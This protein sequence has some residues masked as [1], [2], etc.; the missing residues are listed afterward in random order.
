MLDGDD[1]KRNVEQRQRDVFSMFVGAGPAKRMT[2]GAL[3]AATGI[4]KSSLADYA[5]GVAMPLHNLLRLV[6]ALPKEAADMLIAPSG[7]RFADIETADANWDKIAAEAA[8]LVSEVC[9]ARSDGVIDHQEEARLKKMTRKLIAD[10]L[11][12][13]GE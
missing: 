6:P 10:A 4:S 12:A 8:G 7:K 3:A 1:F 11:G 5:N 2:F 13:V 9:T